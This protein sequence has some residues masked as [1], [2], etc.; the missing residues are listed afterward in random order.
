MSSVDPMTYAHDHGC[1]MFWEITSYP[2]LWGHWMA[3]LYCNV[4]G[5]AIVPYGYDHLL[6]ESC[7]EQD[8]REFGYSFWRRSHQLPGVYFCSDHGRAL[9]CFEGR[10]AFRS[11]PDEVL[12]YS[13]LPWFLRRL[14]CRDARWG[15]EYACM[16]RRMAE[17]PWE[18]P[19]TARLDFGTL[20]GPWAE[21]VRALVYGDSN[22]I[23]SWTEKTPRLAHEPFEAQLARFLLRRDLH[24]GPDQK[25]ARVAIAGIPD[26]A[27]WSMYCP[28][29]SRQ[30]C[31]CLTAAKRWAKHRWRGVGQT[32]GEVQFNEL[33]WSA[34]R[35]SLRGHAP[36]VQPVTYSATGGDAPLRGCLAAADRGDGALELEANPESGP[37]GAPSWRRFPVRRHPL[38]ALSARGR[39]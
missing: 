11:A 19:V 35:L 22:R 36:C 20:A 17:M 33:Q 28:V 13:E 37:V 2:V 26:A 4:V 14:T 5:L 23:W 24:G 21:M 9:L 25:I 27:P 7:V 1:S 30:I 15:L 34:D 16:A 38:P 10:E 8:L 18:L 31:L 12:C 6:C 29:N 32:A 39:Q 3:F